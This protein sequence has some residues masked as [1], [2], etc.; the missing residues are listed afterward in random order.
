M[1]EKQLVRTYDSVALQGMA[2]AF[3]TWLT[4]RLDGPLP[5][6]LIRVVGATDEFWPK[7]RE[8][9]RLTDPASTENWENT[10]SA[11][12][13]FLAYDRSSGRMVRIPRS[14]KGDVLRLLFP[15]ELKE[16]KGLRRCDAAVFMRLHLMPDWA[17]REAVLASECA[18]IVE[19][20]VA[21]PLNLSEGFDPK[22]LGW[23]NE[24]AA[25]RMRNPAETTR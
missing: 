24:F 16:V 3:T 11:M 8:P 20:W 19:A 17:Y 1:R 25:E 22:V 14:M 18:R 5:A 15:F 10:D 6:P 12:F 4:R 2:N 21:K 9:S 7:L 13:Y 23:L